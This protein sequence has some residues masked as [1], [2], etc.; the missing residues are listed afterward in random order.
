MAI[1]PNPEDIERV[2]QENIQAIEQKTAEQ[3]AHGKSFNLPADG[4]GSGIIPEDVW[5]QAKK[6]GEAK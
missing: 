2:N 3:N 1:Q 6:D 5:Q 4:H